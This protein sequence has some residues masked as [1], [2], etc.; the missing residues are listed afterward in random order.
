MKSGAEDM[1]IV[2]TLFYLSFTPFSRL[3]H[4]HTSAVDDKVFP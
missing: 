3:Y 4:L 2:F 1:G